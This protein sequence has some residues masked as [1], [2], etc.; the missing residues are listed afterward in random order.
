MEM[1]TLEWEWGHAIHRGCWGGD[2]DMVP[3]RDIGMGMK[4]LEWGWSHDIHRGCW[5]GDIG[6]GMGTLGWRWGRWSGN[7]DIGMGTC[8][9]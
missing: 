9:P 8:H 4:M 1:G 3:I 2:G 5:D 6:V 7:G